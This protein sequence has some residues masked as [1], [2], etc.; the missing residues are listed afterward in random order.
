MI[1]LPE[2]QESK[3]DTTTTPWQTFFDSCRQRACMVCANDNSGCALCEA[4]QLQFRRGGGSQRKWKRNAICS[5]RYHALVPALTL[6]AGE[7]ALPDARNVCDGL[8]P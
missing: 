3:F 4:R 1:Q 5:F 6:S 8:V 7:Y 2:C